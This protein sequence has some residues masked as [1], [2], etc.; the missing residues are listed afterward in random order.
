MTLISLKRELT[1]VEFARAKFES[2]TLIRPDPNMMMTN[3]DLVSQ[4]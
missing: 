4:I 3:D 1:L 2:L